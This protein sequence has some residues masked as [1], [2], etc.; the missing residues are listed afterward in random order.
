MP[1]D[2][3]CRMLAGAP[4]DTL[5][6]STETESGFTEDDTSPVCHTPSCPRSAKSSRHC[7]CGVITTSA[8]QANRGFSVLSGIHFAEI[9]EV[10]RG[11]V[12]IFFSLTHCHLY[13]AQ[14]QRQKSPCHDEFRA[15]HLAQVALA[16]TTTTNT[17]YHK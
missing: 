8:P 1:L 13:G 7:L 11:R 2:N 12:A 5:V 4:P 15:R 6:I 16:T 14:G 17:Y 3:K 9:V 10:E